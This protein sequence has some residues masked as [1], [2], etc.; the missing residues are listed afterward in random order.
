M[1]KL[2]KMILDNAIKEFPYDSLVLSGGYGLNCYILVALETIK[3]YELL[4]EDALNYI[5]DKINEFNK[6]LL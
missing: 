4:E 5:G 6:E 1:T 3:N 2:Q